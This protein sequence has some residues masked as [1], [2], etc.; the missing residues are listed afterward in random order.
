MDTLRIIKERRSVREFT[1]D[2]VIEE[3]VMRVLEAG[4]WAPSGLNNQPW[5]FSVIREDKL[6]D[7]IAELTNYGHIIRN[8]PVSI[9]I[10]L[11]ESASYDRTK[12][13]LA[14][15]ACIQNM[16]IT[17]HSLDL[18]AV[19]LG[20][21]L[22]NKERVSELLGVGEEFELMAIVAIGHPVEKSRVSE[23]KALEELIL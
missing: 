14:V 3:N 19:W 15:G 1:P 13:L 5:R 23:R 7:Q 9:A 8:A 20:E 2:N 11:D 16:L 6:K 10:F 4:R 21:I 22:K 12:D 17:A 18:G